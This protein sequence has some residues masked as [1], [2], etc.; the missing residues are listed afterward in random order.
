MYV[1]L[2]R[3]SMKRLSILDR[4]SFSPA[5]CVS[6]LV[7]KLVVV[8]GERNPASLAPSF[9]VRGRGSKGTWRG[10]TFRDLSGKVDRSLVST[11][12]ISERDSTPR[13]LRP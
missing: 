1:L 13:P 6:T 4:D 12:V 7:V 11:D 2:L 5:T 9:R 8:G 3:F 10:V